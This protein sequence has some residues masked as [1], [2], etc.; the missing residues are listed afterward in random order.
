MTK[1]HRFRFRIGVALVA[2]MLAGCA[3]QPQNQPQGGASP[4]GAAAP[5][6]L[7]F[8]RFFG[9]CAQAHQG[10]TDPAKAQGE[11]GIIQVLTNKWNAEH[12]EAQIETT[13][14]E[15][16]QH[17][18]RLTA[19]I[20]AGEPPDIV[21]LH[22]RLL[23]N[24]ASRGLLTPLD[25]AFRQAGIDVNDFLPTAREHASHDG[26]LYALPYDLQTVLWHINVDLW[27]Q[28]GLV[29]D[30]G[31]PRLPKNRAEFM[32]A[33][34][35]MKDR[36]GKQFITA[37]MDGFIG[38]IW[39][40]DALVWQQGGELFGEAEGKPKANVDTPQMRNAVNFMMELFQQGYAPNKADYGAAES[41]FLK[42]EVASLLNGTWGV[43]IYTPQVEQG[44]ASFKTY[45][46]APYPQIFD[47]PAAWSD[48]HTWAIPS[49]QNP[50]E[51]KIRAA[52]Q[53]L[54][55]LHD[56]NVHWSRTGHLTV[57]NSVNSSG[58]YTGQPHRM[59]YAGAAEIVRTEP[60]IRQIEAYRTVMNEELT[61]IY[62]GQK[63]VE[64]G[65][66][67]AQRRVDEALALSGL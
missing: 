43:G 19:G 46:V 51:N 22:G 36:T 18:Q 25:D 48:S 24:F 3:G 45:Y 29:D 21:I 1:L 67:D 50:D 49:R 63:P 9:D 54:K 37:Q 13:V 52:V 5:V 40:A 62:L 56:N 28:A 16:D 53:F 42:G 2:V 66:A 39:T 20:A 31:K 32:A 27:K 7:S 59:E 6:K 11:C 47:R 57:R 15:H 55:Y 65:L 44:K 8:H 41:A 61:A 10:Q 38:T 33:A 17:Y 26:K 30:A 35:Q 58:D 23:P 60:R 4:G 12:P 34:K 64:R 14:V